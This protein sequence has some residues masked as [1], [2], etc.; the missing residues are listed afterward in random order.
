[1]TDL[2]A[3][4]PL[5]LGVV[6]VVGA[7]L[8]PPLVIWLRRKIRENN[9]IRQL[10]SRGQL[11]EEEIVSSLGAIQSELLVTLAN[12]EQRGDIRRIQENAINQDHKMY[13]R[14]LYTL[15]QQ[16]WKRARGLDV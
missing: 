9:V 13:M 7:C 2:L 5:L 8:S 6:T 11:D 4:L 12:L 16:G 14:I 1:M 15:T 10:G 3:T